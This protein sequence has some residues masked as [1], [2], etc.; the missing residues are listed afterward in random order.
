[1]ITE[2]D[3]LRIREMVA[4]R[5]QRSLPAAAISQ[6]PGL[7]VTLKDGRAEILAEDRCAL[8]RGYFLLGCALRENQT[9]LDIRQERHFSSCGVMV[10]VSRNAVLTVDA[11]KRAL[12]CLAM[13][14]MNLLLLYMEDTYTVPEYPYLGYLRGRYSQDELR[15]LDRYAA[16]LD[17][18]LMP[19]VQVLGHMEQ[20]LQWESS[21]PLRD[22]PDILRPDWPATYDFLDKAIASLRACFRTGRIHVGMDEAYGVGLGQYYAEHGPTD[23]FELLNRHVQ[24]V[25]EICGRH[26]FRPIMWSDM[27]FRLGSRRGEYYDPEAEIPRRVIDALPAIDLCY[28]DYYHTDEAFYDA[29]LSGHAKLGRTVFAGGIWTWSG[30][31]PHVKRTRATM[32]P[33]LRACA[34]HQVDTVFATMW[35][36]DGA[37]TDV[38]LAFNQL[39]IFSEACWQG[40]DVSDEALARL[41]EQLTG[42]P[43]E[44]FT[45]FGEFYPSERERCTGKGLIWCD[46]LY[47]MMEFGFESMRDAAARFRRAAETLA[48]Y[49]DSAEC[50]YA[51]LCFQT[52]AMKGELV[53]ELRDRY[54]AHDRAWLRQ[55]VTVTIPAL[56]EQ[57]Q[58][59]LEAHRGLW[60]RDMKRFGWEILALRYGAVTGRLA[61]VQDELS[62]Y[63][64]GE[65]PAIPELDEVPLPVFRRAGQ[66]FHGF[67]T[68]NAHL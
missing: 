68:P 54:L 34:R 30:F 60:E 17:I 44:A 28:W 29:M 59:L 14:G 36:D 49:P 6:G 13:L 46:P 63:L 10:D 5:M 61:D 23:R 27:Y 43:E 50:R 52:A 20:F 1:M 24:R 51:R 18:E 4:R 8:A 22:Q 19:C 66:H 35:G 9:A 64:A 15:E 39:P 40:A 53:A 25:C 3:H 16:S 33:A 26:G 37:E 58:R 7:R 12:D 21:A 56:Q 2:Q 31:L 42:V 57:Y 55:T 47:P 67:V 48:G 38:F 45:A 11:A 65:L 41:G 62:R 32:G